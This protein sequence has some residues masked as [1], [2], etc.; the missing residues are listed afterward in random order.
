MWTILKVFIEF[1][2]VLCLFYVLV[3]WPLALQPG[4]KP[5]SPALEGE[6]LPTGPSGKSLSLLLYEGSPTVLKRM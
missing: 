6:V 1:V 3:F 5:V 2:T 4:L